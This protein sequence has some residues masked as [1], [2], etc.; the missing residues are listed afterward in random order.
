MEVVIFVD[1]KDIYKEI[2]KR[3]SA[4]R[5]KN[6]LTQETLASMLSV[7][8]KHISH[9]ENGTSMLSLK[10]LILLCNEFSCSLDYIIL[11]RNNPDTFIPDKIYELINIGSDVE[12]ELLLK[13]LGLFV[14]I[15]G[16]NESI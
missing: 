7:T 13:Y 15:L 2:G 8:T 16:R 5:K 10:A 11:G 3:I 14:E 6:G 12:K 9:V 4:I 1:D